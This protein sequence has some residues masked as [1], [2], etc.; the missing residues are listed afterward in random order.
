[1]RERIEGNGVHTIIVE[2]ANRFARDLMVQGIGYA[3][4]RER[5]IEL[6]A[7]DCPTSFLDDGPT[8]KLIRQ[9][10]GAIAE[11]D[12]ATVAKLRGARDRIRKERGGDYTIDKPKDMVHHLNQSDGVVQ[13]CPL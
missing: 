1:M 6:I 11:F 9:V 4:L 10:L 2:T 13:S 5:G 12:K 3:K 7:A 8:S